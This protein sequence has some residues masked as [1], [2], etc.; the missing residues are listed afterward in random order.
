MC[1]LFSL[2]RSAHL[3]ARLDKSRIVPA[4][5]IEPPDIDSPPWLLGICR[6]GYSR[7][8]KTT[9]SETGGMTNIGSVSGKLT[10]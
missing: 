9:T 3:A 4:K 7:A 8:K 10:E 6:W 2:L 5:L 1:D